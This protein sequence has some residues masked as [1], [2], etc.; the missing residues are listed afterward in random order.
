MFFF[1]FFFFPHPFHP[2]IMPLPSSTA[3]ITKHRWQ[4]H[5]TSN[6]LTFFF[7][8]FSFTLFY[9]FHVF[10][11][12]FLNSLIRA[13]NWYLITHIRIN[14]ATTKVQLTL[15]HSNCYKDLDYGFNIYL[16]E[17]TSSLNDTNDASWMNRFSTMVEKWLNMLKETLKCEAW[18][19]FR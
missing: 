2:R 7:L 15:L 13:T 16:K 12:I 17:K 3:P 1:F 10:F 14:Y 18:W 5:S 9:L 11:L 4:H 6:S 19:E 8:S